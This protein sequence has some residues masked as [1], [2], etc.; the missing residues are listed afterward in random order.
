MAKK[1]S[2]G[3]VNHQKQ[4]SYDIYNRVY[5][6]LY[7][8]ILQDEKTNYYTVAKQAEVSRTY[9]YNHN[10]FSMMIET[11][12][13]LQKENESEDSLYE[14]FELGGVGGSHN[15]RVFSQIKR[16]LYFLLYPSDRKFFN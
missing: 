14:K 7:E 8:M 3:I 11:F 2:E 4:R 13:N 9:L 6:T 1:N 16:V 12:L 5:K 10:A 15:K